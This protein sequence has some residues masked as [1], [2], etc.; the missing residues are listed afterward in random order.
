MCRQLTAEF[1]EVNRSWDAWKQDVL[2]L[3]NLLWQAWST[4]QEA[5][6]L[7]RE[8]LPDVPSEGLDETSCLPDGD[9]MA[10]SPMHKASTSTLPDSTAD[11][12]I[13]ASLCSD[14][15][16]KFATKLREA[17]Y[18]EKAILCNHIF[19]CMGC[20]SV[21]NPRDGLVRRHFNHGGIVK[22]L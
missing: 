9:A 6:D 3:L 22:H 13:P 11:I 15:P 19:Q 4:L 10:D 20:G 14:R 12:V 5:P 18:V 2:E 1:R 21:S 17:S 7:R 8:D 16:P